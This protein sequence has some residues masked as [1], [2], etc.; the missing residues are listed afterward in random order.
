MTDYCNELNVFI[1]HYYS[2]LVS[3]N[4]SANTQHWL[5]VLSWTPTVSLSNFLL[6]LW[7]LNLTLE[8][9]TN[10]GLLYL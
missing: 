6:Y 5:F 2:V 4:Q 8:K 10:T 9:N 3:L 1:N 7:T